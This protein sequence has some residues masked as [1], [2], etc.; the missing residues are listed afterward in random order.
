MSVLSRASS[1]QNAFYGEEVNKA[2][3]GSS[4]AHALRPIYPM[5]H[6]KAKLSYQSL[7]AKRD[8]V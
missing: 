7:G 5:L 3:I 2:N 6:I 4:F 8:R 1:S